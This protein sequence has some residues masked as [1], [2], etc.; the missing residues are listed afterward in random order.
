MATLKKGQT[1][2]GGAVIERSMV[3]RWARRQ[4]VTNRQRVVAGG[5][6]AGFENALDCLI[7]YLNTQPKRTLR[8]GGTGRR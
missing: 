7:E 4:K 2:G 8:A 6:V 5:F 3:R 1:V